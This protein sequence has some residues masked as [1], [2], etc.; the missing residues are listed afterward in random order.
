MS[1]GGLFAA[2]ASVIRDDE[3]QN[4]WRRVTDRAPGFREYQDKTVREIPLISAQ[5]CALIR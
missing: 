1:Q 2:R 3:Y 5:T 4:W